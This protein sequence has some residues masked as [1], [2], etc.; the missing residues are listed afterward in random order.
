M[1]RLGVCA[2]V[3]LAAVGFG[4]AGQV[5]EE[6]LDARLPVEGVY[7]VS[8]NEPEADCEA[9]TYRPTAHDQPDHLGG[10]SD[11]LVFHPEG[12]F[13]FSSGVWTSG[14][15]IRC[16]V[17]HLGR[18]TCP[19]HFM[20]DSTDRDGIWNNEWRLV[21]QFEGT[22][23]ESRESLTASAAVEA[24][25]YGSGCEDTVSRLN[26]CTFQLVIEA[27]LRQAE[28]FVDPRDYVAEER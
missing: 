18:F 10:G 1:N 13:H 16:P 14:G 28:P 6:E 5:D 23:D 24:T 21:Y 9:G 11:M 4:C 26:T 19:Q 17:D 3:V 22:I 12:Q 8:F 27:T 25:C 15:A 2:F 7:T 20:W